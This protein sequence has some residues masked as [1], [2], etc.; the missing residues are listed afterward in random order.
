MEESLGNSGLDCSVK[1]PLQQPYSSI[2]EDLLFKFS[3]NESI[4]SRTLAVNVPTTNTEM[5]LLV[6]IV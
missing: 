4:K 2:Q 6:T 5:L 1:W 3:F